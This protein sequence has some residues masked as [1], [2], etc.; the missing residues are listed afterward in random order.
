[1]QTE[2]NFRLSTE[3][4]L[5]AAV[6]RNLYQSSKVDFEWIGTVLFKLE[7]Q[8]LQQQSDWCIWW[9]SSHFQMVFRVASVVPF[10]IRRQQ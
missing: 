7:E 3:E 6:D 8:Y 5:G 2:R 4:N 10:S 9:M 1:M